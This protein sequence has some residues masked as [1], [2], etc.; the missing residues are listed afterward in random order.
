MTY[1]ME[2]WRSPSGILANLHGFRG[3]LKARAT[4]DRT[5]PYA[6]NGAQ[7]PS[8]PGAFGRLASL[9]AFA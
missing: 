3:G 9:E 6:A 2:F 1:L 8:Y 4:P 5:S 7:R